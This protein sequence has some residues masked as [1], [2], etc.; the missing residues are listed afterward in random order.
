MSEY[1]LFSDVKKVSEYKR[2]FQGGV[3]FFPIKFSIASVV[4]YNSG[5]Y[6]TCNEV[7]TQN[8]FLFFLKFCPL[9]R[10]CHPN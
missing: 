9:L 3:Q 4:E 1:D 8:L 6:V 10:I 7:G 5:L 2:L